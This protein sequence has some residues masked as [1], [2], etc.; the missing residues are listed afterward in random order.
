MQN[1]KN[2]KIEKD[3]KL[4]KTPRNSQ[5][6]TSN[7]QVAFITT[8]QKNMQEKKENKNMSVIQSFASNSKNHIQN[9]KKFKITYSGSDPGSSTAFSLTKEH[10]RKNKKG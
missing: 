5:K 4:T 3:F 6:H 1:S 2:S 7:R 9:S 8:P 10:A